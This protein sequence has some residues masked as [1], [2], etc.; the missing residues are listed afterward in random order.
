MPSMNIMSYTDEKKKVFDKI[1]SL[2]LGLMRDYSAWDG[3][4]DSSSKEF[5]VVIDGSQDSDVYDVYISFFLDDYFLFQASL[6]D[7]VLFSGDYAIHLP[8]Q[9]SLLV[10][11]DDLL[12]LISLSNS[13]EYGEKLGDKLGSPT[14]SAG[15]SKGM[16]YFES[17]LGDSLVFL[18]DGYS[19]SIGSEIKCGSDKRECL[20][21]YSKVHNILT[22]FLI[23]NTSFFSF[24]PKLLQ[25]N[26]TYVMERGNVDLGLLEGY[27]K[28]YY[29]DILLFE[30]TLPT[31]FVSGK[32]SAWG[33]ESKLLEDD[34]NSLFNELEKVVSFVKCEE[35]IGITSKVLL[36][37][38]GITAYDKFGN[39]VKFV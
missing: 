31:N 4:E 27:L 9:K 10:F 33:I 2:V 28:A 32:N 3:Y 17:F 13:N 8:D 39:W 18:A 24:L 11:Y 5:T 19:P 29:G 38:D 16:L 12:E 14:V 21:S 7:T 20:D 34:Y 30:V 23:R 22:N 1:R 15:L 6:Q 36:E 26:L 37:H 35:L 25:S